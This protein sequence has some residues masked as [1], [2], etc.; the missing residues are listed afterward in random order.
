MTAPTPTRIAGLTDPVVPPLERVPIRTRESGATL[1]AWKLAA[2]A[3]EGTGTVVRVEIGSGS[4]YRGEG[5]FLGWTQEA[6][7][8]AW[9]ALLPPAP[10]D[11]FHTQQLG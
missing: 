10:V 3:P 8:S 11:T 1:S 9:T 2:S 5:W 7:A 6:L 4:H